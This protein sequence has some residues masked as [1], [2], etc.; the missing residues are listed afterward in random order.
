MH[1]FFL[2]CHNINLMMANQIVIQL[3]LS[4]FQKKSEAHQ[5][6]CRCYHSH[7]NRSSFEL[8][9]IQRSSFAT[10]NQSTSLIFTFENLLSSSKNEKNH[11]FAV[12]V[13]LQIHQQVRAKR[14][15]FFWKNIKITVGDW[16][17]SQI[18]VH[19]MIRGRATALSRLQRIVRAHGD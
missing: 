12:C 19:A 1:N 9:I 4:E 2:D 14:V 18:I 7:W 5:C 8:Q 16:S 6:N 10:L 3:E 15:I 17:Y 13:G 11:G